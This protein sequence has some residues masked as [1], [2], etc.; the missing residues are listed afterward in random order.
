MNTTHFNQ[1]LE[2]LKEI[3]KLKLVFR[4]SRLIDDF[5]RHEDSAQHSWHL[6]FYVLILKEYT[7]EP[8]DVLTALKMV[9]LHDVIEI[10]SGDTFCYDAE[11]VATQE[12]REQEAATKIFQLL[13]PTQAKEYH[14]LWLEFEAG[15]T[16]EARFATA[17]DCMQP[18]MQHMAHEGKGWREKNVKRC[19]VEKRMAPIKAGSEKLWAYIMQQ[20]DEAVKKGYL[21]E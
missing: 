13:P 4:Q 12:A 16:P 8:F 10:Y 11:A 7:N 19:Q 20:I 9:L 18:I 5:E 14:Q 17:V 15:E 2:F 6:A 1:Q 3:D 21:E